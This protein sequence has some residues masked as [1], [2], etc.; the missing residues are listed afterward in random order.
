MVGWGAPLFSRSGGN[1]KFFCTRSH[2]QSTDPYPSHFEDMSSPRSSPAP[3]TTSINITAAMPAGR[4]LDPAWSHVEID[5]EGGVWCKKCSKLIQ[6]TGRTHIERVKHHLAKKCASRATTSLITDTYRPKMKPSVLKA[7]HEQLALWVFSSGLAFYK[8]EHASLLEA[9]QLLAPAV[10]LPNR[11]ELSNALLDRAYDKSL[12]MPM[13]AMGKIV[14]VS[15]DGWTDVC[16]QAVINYMAVCGK[17][18][19]FLESVYTGNQSHTS[20]F[21]A[22]DMQRVIEKYG[23]LDVGAVITDNTAANKAMWTALKLKFPRTFFHG[24]VCHALH[25]LVKDIVQRLPWFSQLQDVCKKLVVF[26]KSH[27]KLWSQ[28]TTRLRGDGLRLLAKPGDTRWGSL[29]L[30]FETVLAAESILLGMV[31]ARDFLSAKTKA[32]KRA[33]RVVFDMVTSSEFVAQLQKAVVVLKPVG[34]G[35]KQLERDDTPIS[36]V[37]KLFMD[38]PSEMQEAGLTVA[39]LKTVKAMIKTRSQFVYGEAHGIAYLL[40]PRYVGAGMDIDTRTAVE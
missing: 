25:L 24:C 6:T 20:D 23:F 19:Y 13:A 30:C 33:R 5:P 39:E 32:K 34:I 1:H 26:F 22:R 21:L 28:L 2:T 17:L 40:D 29:Q 36:C 16:G 27:H 31:T 15:S 18:C 12:K 35:L 3:T 4:K 14:T 8:V 7:F 9:L 10:E 11:D 37:Y 38:L